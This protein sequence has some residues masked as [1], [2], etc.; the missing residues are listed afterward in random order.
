MI[1]PKFRDKQRVLIVGGRHYGAVAPITEVPTCH[2]Y[3]YGVR[4]D[5]RIVP[6]P[7]YLLEATP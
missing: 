4:I 3:V 2:P 5:G 1:P 7:E 6:V